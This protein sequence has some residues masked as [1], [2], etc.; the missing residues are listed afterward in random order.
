MN[1]AVRTTTTIARTTMCA[2]VVGLHLVQVNVLQRLQ[3]DL[4]NPHQDITGEKGLKLQVL[5]PLRNLHLQN[6]IPDPDRL[7]QVILPS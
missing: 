6:L 2:D 1:G 4:F 3:K 5:L 7:L